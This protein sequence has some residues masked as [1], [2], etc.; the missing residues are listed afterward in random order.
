[1]RYYRIQLQRDDGTPVTP[2]SLG[3]MPISSLLPNGQ[4]NPGALQVELDI[5]VAPYNTPTGTGLVRV[6]GIGL[7]QISASFDLNGLAISVYGGMSPGLPLATAAAPQAGLLAQGKIIQ[8]F[9]NWVGT[10]QSIDI[11]FTASTGTISDQKNIVLHWQPGVSMGTALKQ[12]LNTAFPGVPT[13]IQ[14]SSAL[15]LPYAETSYHFS[16]TE[17]AYLVNRISK[18]V[19]PSPEYAGVQIGIVG[20]TI[21]VWD[22]TQAPTV[23]AKAIAFQDLI[24][25]PTWRQP[26]VISV[27]TVMRGDL[28]F[29]Q[30]I[31]LPQG[32]PVTTTAAAQPAFNG[33][34]N[35]LTFSGNW[36]LTALRHIGN[37]RQPTAEA[38]VSVLELTQNAN[39]SAS[40]SAATESA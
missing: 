22:G 35:K 18:V 17:L 29:Q 16:L 23:P 11:L 37:F 1:M 10:D 30:P 12:A 36:Q 38:W 4:F 9:G 32:I 34:Q 21:Y 40:S 24:G 27:K 20:G 6:W 5:P 39:S 28:D 19:D 8:S 14:V 13:N 2:A 25:Q 15:V 26:G 7:Q 3:G 31:T 33:Y